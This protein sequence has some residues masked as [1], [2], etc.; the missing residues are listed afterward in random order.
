MALMPLEDA[1]PQAFNDRIDKLH[2]QYKQQCNNTIVLSDSAHSFNIFENDVIKTWVRVPRSHPGWSSISI[3]DWTLLRPII[4][5]NL[6]EMNCTK[7]QQ[8]TSARIERSGQER[9]C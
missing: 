1:W 8:S 2:P 6:I 3:K 9:A 7:I 4:K 5:E